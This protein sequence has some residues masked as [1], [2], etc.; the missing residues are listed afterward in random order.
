MALARLDSIQGLPDNHPVVMSLMNHWNELKSPIDTSMSSLQYYAYKDNDYRGDLYMELGA[1]NWCE[2]YNI[3]HAH[4]C[5][6]GMEEYCPTNG[7]WKVKYAADSTLELYVT[8]RNIFNKYHITYLTGD[9]FHYTYPIYASDTLTYV[10]DAGIKQRLHKAKAQIAS[11]YDARFDV[12][13]YNMDERTYVNDSLAEGAYVD[14]PAYHVP[15]QIVFYKKGKLKQSVMFNA[16]SDM[17]LPPDPRVW[18]DSTSF[19]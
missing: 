8:T 14:F 1:G 2:V 7:K 11:V 3:P 15:T 10:S 4:A 16:G 18:L 12:R 6:E 9:E 17:Q 19:E 5:G 13:L